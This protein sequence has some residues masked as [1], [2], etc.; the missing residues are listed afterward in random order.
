MDSIRI[1]KTVKW[2]LL[3]DDFIHRYR[4]NKNPQIDAI[5]VGN[6]CAVFKFIFKNIF[7]MVVQCT[8]YNIIIFP[9]L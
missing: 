4:L 2:I 6:Y 7:A 3:K 9:I 5:V 1:N 8:Q